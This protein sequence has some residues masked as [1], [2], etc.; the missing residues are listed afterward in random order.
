MRKIL[1]PIVVIV[2]AAIL[3]VTGMM[4]F[5]AVRP[6]EP[7]P[8]TKTAIHTKAVKSIVT[9]QPDANDATAEPGAGSDRSD[10]AD[11]PGGHQD[12]PGNV[13]HQCDGNCNE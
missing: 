7:T 10:A 9:V 8:M 4:A 1:Q 2:A 11:A 12:P 5:A 6:H 13:D 3:A